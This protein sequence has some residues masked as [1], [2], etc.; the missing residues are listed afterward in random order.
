MA[1]DVN[2]K[3]PSWETDNPRCNT[4]HLE[5]TTLIP[6]SCVAI[7][8]LIEFINRNEFNILLFIYFFIKFNIFTVIYLNFGRSTV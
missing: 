1:L 3:Q 4:D 6:L 2:E 7:K 5:S 8:F